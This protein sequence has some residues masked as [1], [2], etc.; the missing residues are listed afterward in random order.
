ML[1]RPVLRPGDIWFKD[2]QKG[3]AKVVKFLMQSPTVWHQLIRWIKGTLEPVL[4]YH[5]GII[6]SN[7]VTYEQQWLVQTKET[8][9]VLNGDN[10]LII[11]RRR[12]LTQGD[13]YAILNIAKREMGQKWGVVHTI[14]GRFPT[15][16]T[17]IPYFARYVKL[18]N[19]EVSAGRV[20]RWM[21]LAWGET[22]GHKRYTEATTHT[23]VK[24][25]FSHPET[26]EVVYDSEAN[27]QQ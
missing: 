10:R 12:G 5:P 23:M 7:D 9:D 3:G 25:C 21:Y 22:F 8:E 18:P 24:W 4:T 2:S 27:R 14:F 13:Q 6:A 17:G 26:Y 15:W 11:F 1:N 19:E 20:A 16:L